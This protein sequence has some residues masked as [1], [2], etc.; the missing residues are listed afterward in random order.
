MGPSG[1][2]STLPQPYQDPSQMSLVSQGFPQNLTDELLT[3]THHVKK[4]L[5][6]CG[7]NQQKHHEIMWKNM[8][9]FHVVDMLLTC[10]VICLISPSIFGPPLVFQAGGTAEISGIGRLVLLSE[11]TSICTTRDWIGWHGLAYFMYICRIY[12]KHQGLSCFFLFA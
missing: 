6:T 5:G 9:S 2:G 4:Y 11:T 10:V 7:K 1:D 8:G 12:L 3:F